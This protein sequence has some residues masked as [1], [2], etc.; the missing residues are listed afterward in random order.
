M[1]PGPQQIEQ[2]SRQGTSSQ[3][4]GPHQIQM[5][6]PVQVHHPILLLQQA[7]PDL[8]E[9]A[10]PQHTA[11]PPVSPPPD[12]TSITA[13]IA[14]SWT[15]APPAQPTPAQPAHPQQNTLQQFRPEQVAAA[16][17]SQPFPSQPLTP[18]E[19]A[20]FITQPLE[21]PFLLQQPFLA[22]EDFM[23]QPFYFTPGQGQGQQQQQHNQF[24][25]QPVSDI[26]REMQAELEG[27][28][29][30]EL[31]AATKSLLQALCLNNNMM[32]AL[33]YIETSTLNGMNNN[34]NNISGNNSNNNNNNN[35]NNIGG[36]NFGS[37]GFGAPSM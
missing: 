28:D 22:Q 2:P 36:G 9:A 8:P 29:N 23:P 35:N 4:V 19:F 21:D 31:P 30:V 25:P 11:R 34:T 32:D 6:R 33:A 27:A 37:N 14:A 26:T 20:A 16:F 3:N 12:F 5:P 1:P 18:E 24:L 15:A 10:P 13:A 7:E 17:A